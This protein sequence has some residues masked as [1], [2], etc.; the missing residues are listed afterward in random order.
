MPRLQELHLLGIYTCPKGQEQEEEEDWQ[1][2]VSQ[3]TCLKALRFT[4]I[5]QD[6]PNR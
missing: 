3:F 4:D 1:G 6:V 5:G 2:V